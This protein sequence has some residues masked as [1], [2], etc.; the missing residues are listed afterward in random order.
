MKG[1]ASRK[2]R[3]ILNRPFIYA[4]IDR[5][6]GLPVFIGDIVRF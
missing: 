2:P 3:V 6:Y 5:K 4:I 1:M